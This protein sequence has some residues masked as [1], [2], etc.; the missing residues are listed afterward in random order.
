MDPN[1]REFVRD[2]EDGDIGRGVT[3][4]FRHSD[5]SYS[6]TFG[7]RWYMFRAT[8]SELQELRGALE[9]AHAFI[10]WNALSCDTLGTLVDVGR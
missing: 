3:P 9:R 1:L 8:T 4:F 6:T 5:G 2:V 7:G 10:E